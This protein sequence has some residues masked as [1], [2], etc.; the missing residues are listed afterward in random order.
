M[1][2][3]RTIIYVNFA[4]YENAGRI[5]DFI[6]DNFS[7]VI[8]FSFDF[9]KL[10]NYQSN[11]IKIFR[12]GKSIR[13][14]KLFKLPTPEFLL[15][16]TLPFIAILIAFQT[17]WYV[18]LFKKT[19][20]KFNYYLSVNAFTA[21]IGNLLKKLHIVDKTIFWVWDYYPPGEPDWK[22][23]LARFVYWEFD[24]ISTQSSN[25]VIFLNRKLEK[26]RK[27]IGVLP[28]R[29]IYPV[30]PIGTN[31]GEIVFSKYIIIGHLGVLKRSQGL[32][33]LFDNLKNILTN[34]PNLKVEIIGS[35]PDEEYFKKR[36]R[37]FSNVKFYGFVEQDN[38]IDRIIENWSIGLATYIPGKSN[39][40]YWTD[41]SKIKAYINH[42]VPVIT[43]DVTGFSREI[44]KYGAGLIVDYYNSN[45]FMKAI[46]MIL[47]KQKVFKVNSHNLAA[48]YYYK[49]IYKQ[50]FV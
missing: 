12:D 43:T 30:V 1:K 36:A 28:E 33:L 39:S 6:I 46:L 18:L 29:G 22:I 45:E 27:K 35:G 25:Q 16:L 42:G 4:P 50:L 26:L 8:L 21:W 23:R 24:K 20:G 9:H 37:I 31:P 15:F 48:K 5:L 40:A 49:K 11:R 17:L 14:I 34:I 38:E 10:N 41:P 44:K 13:E 19:Y 2:Q 3:N 47:D 32:D 7:L